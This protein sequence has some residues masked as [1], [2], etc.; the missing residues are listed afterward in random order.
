V[1]YINLLEDGGMRSPNISNHPDIVDKWKYKHDAPG[2]YHAE[3]CC[4]WGI[5]LEKACC[6]QF[7]LIDDKI[8][9]DN[10][11]PDYMNK[12]SEKLSYRIRPLML[13]D[14]RNLNR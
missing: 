10:P 1:L 6:S 11:K 7:R 3:F 8:S 4:V 5:F 14:L 2:Y 9:K 12:H 13:R